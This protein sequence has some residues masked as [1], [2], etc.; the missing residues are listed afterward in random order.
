MTDTND[1]IKAKIRKLLEMTTERGATEAEAMVAMEKA[2]KLLEQHNL[3][4]T[5]LRGA[6]EKKDHREEEQFPGFPWARD[7][8][9]AVAELYDCRHLYYKGGDQKK[10]RQVFVGRQSNAETARLIAEFVVNTVRK[11]GKQYQREVDGANRQGRDFMVGASQRIVKRAKQLWREANAEA[12]AERRAKADRYWAMRPDPTAMKPGTYT[13]TIRSGVR[14][15]YA[16]K[17]A[18][19]TLGH[20]AGMGHYRGLV[21]NPPRGAYWLQITCVAGELVNDGESY[22]YELA[23][24]PH[25]SKGTDNSDIKDTEAFRAGQKAGDEIGLRVQVGGAPDANKVEG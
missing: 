2:Q 25:A 22:W 17:G 21:A 8:A 5:E 18:V 10:M 16:Q 15:G 9:S 12:I 3:S 1:S 14:G 11:L 6:G 4:I 23:Q 7:I 20:E 19:L 24:D 13:I